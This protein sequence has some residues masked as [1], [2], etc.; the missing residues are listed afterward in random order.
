M[1]RTFVSLQSSPEEC[2]S[3][4]LRT[5]TRSTSI[6]IEEP[7]AT[8]HILSNPKNVHALEIQQK[9]RTALWCQT[10][11]PMIGSPILILTTPKVDGEAIVAAAKLKPSTGSCKVMLG[12]PSR[13]KQTWTPINSSSSSTS[14]S[15]EL[16]SFTYE[17]HKYIWRKFV[18]TLTPP[19]P[20]TKKKRRKL[21]DELH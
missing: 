7:L 18:P 15:S 2:M 16:L 5:R 11:R 20:H 8:H 3:G 10:S 4:A 12:D 6:G 1:F 21:K 13:I 14:S 19:F 17:G 9:G